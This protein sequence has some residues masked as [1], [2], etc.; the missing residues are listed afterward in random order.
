MAWA[1]WLKHIP[2]DGLNMLVLGTTVWA[3]FYVW[4]W[5]ARRHPLA[6]WDLFGFITGLLG[7]RRR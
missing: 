6:G 2:T 1:D 5:I 7:G 3:A 4:F